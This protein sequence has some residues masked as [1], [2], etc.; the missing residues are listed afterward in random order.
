MKPRLRQI[1]VPGYE[2]DVYELKHVLTDGRKVA[3]VTFIVHWLDAQRMKGGPGAAMEYAL[4]KAM[5]QLEN[6][7]VR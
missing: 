5:R 6:A 7:L 1:I 3:R 4:R 2:S